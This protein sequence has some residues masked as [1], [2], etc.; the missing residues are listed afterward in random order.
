MTV[1]AIEKFNFHG[2]TLDVVRLDDGDVGVIIKRACEVMGLDYSAQLAKLKKTDWATV[3]IITTVGQD[4]REREMVTL[5]RRSLPGWLFSLNA[6]KVKPALRDK[7]ATYQREAAEALA[8]RFIGPRKADVRELNASLREREGTILQLRAENESLRH[9]GGGIIGDQRAE[10]HILAPM[11]KIARAQ[12]FC[13]MNAALYASLHTRLDARLRLHVDFPKSKGQGWGVL[14]IDKL[15][16]AQSKL[17]EELAYAEERAELVSKT[18]E[19]MQENDLF[20]FAA[21]AQVTKL[22]LA[23]EDAAE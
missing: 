10:M 19:R 17:A 14:S 7:L 4:G 21:S 8:D 20:R 15:G 18:V 1:S 22:Q 9:L 23:N 2:D 6:G 3:A 5:H 12:A 11:R 16:R 13:E